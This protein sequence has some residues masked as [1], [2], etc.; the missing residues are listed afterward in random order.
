MRYVWS[1]RLEHAARLLADAPR[2]PIAEVA[3]QCGF[4]NAAHFSRAFKERYAMTPR[5]YAANHKVVRA[6]T[7]EGS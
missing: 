2:S 5:E 6:D 4:A 1:L 3:F 7:H